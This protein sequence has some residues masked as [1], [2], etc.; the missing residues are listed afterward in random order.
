MGHSNVI[1]PATKNT[2]TAVLSQCDNGVAGRVKD[3]TRDGT[4]SHSV[5][6]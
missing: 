4:G 6:Q 2:T 5:T 1:G 3:G